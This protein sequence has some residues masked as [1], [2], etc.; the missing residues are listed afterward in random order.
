MQR[1]WR[2][3]RESPQVYSTCGRCR[4]AFR[5]PHEPISF[6]FGCVC[7]TDYLRLH[8]RT[9]N[10]KVHKERGTAGTVA[11]RSNWSIRNRS[12]APPLADPPCAASSSS[13][14]FTRPCIVQ[15]NP[16]DDDGDQWFSPSSPHNSL[17]PA[18]TGECGPNFALQYEVILRNLS[19]LRFA[20][21][22]VALLIVL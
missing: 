7:Y 12:W 21:H 1:I 4:L 14:C 11:W 19:C 6:N 5:F 8:D 16:D 3:I 20:T 10:K 2:S 15:E 13:A 9:I 18:H 22:N 17:L